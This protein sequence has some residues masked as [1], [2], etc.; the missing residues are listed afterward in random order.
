[1][2]ADKTR[3]DPRL[4][5]ETIC[6]ECGTAK[7]EHSNST[8]QWCTPQELKN[9]I[10]LCVASGTPDPRTYWGTFR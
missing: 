6:V 7:G 1:M 5:P 3:P 2:S 10:E 9:E 8:K 4:P